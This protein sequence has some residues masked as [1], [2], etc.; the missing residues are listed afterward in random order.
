MRAESWLRTM[1]PAKLARDVMGG[2]FITYRREDSAGWAGRLHDRLSERFGR[3]TVF[4]GV[5]TLA[6]RHD[7]PTAI[8]ET[9]DRCDVLIAM[10]GRRWLQA[11]L[12]SRDSESASGPPPPS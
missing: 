11:T 9:I 2:I 4:I 8:A 10:I 7:F 12:Q 1:T 6:P 3:D 5:D